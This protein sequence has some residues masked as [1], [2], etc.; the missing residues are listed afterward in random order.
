MS[1]REPVTVVKKDH[2][3]R[4]KVRYEGV[5]LRRD[6][7]EIVLEARFNLDDFDR[8]YTVFRRG[9]RFVEHFFSDRWYNIFEIH[10]VDDDHLKG[11]YYN[12]ARPAVFGDGLIESD[13]LELDLWVGPDG[14]KLVL[15]RKEFNRL[16]IAQTERAA[17]LAA[18][19]ELEARL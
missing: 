5:I 12:F 2:Q 7:S 11:W 6:E 15:D 14:R 17:V 1:T 18:L 19:E 10:D 8:G 13:D 4:E 16:L 9:D 3:G